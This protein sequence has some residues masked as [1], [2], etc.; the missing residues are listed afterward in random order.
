MRSFDASIQQMLWPEKRLRDAEL[1]DKVEG[2]ID[3]TTARSYI[4]I[5]KSFVPALP[6]AA[7]AEEQRLLEKLVDAQGNISLGPIPQGM[8]VNLL[9]SLQPLAES[10]DP[11]IIAQH[12]GRILKLLVDLKIAL[13]TAPKGASDAE[14]RQHFAGLRGPLM[15]L[16]KCPDY[17]VNRGHYFGT[18]K[19]N[20]TTGLTDQEKAWGPQPVL[21]DA[22]KRALVEYLKTL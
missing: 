10:K 15:S 21:A 17:V 8:P 3:R 14:L 5:P 6:G 1:G 18:A 4:F 22:E 7:G 12:Y 16:S 20:D 11:K 13:A 2:V 19:F 9:A